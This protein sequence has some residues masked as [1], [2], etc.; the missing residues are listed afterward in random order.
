MRKKSWIGISLVLALLII[1]LLSLYIFKNKE[2]PIDNNGFVLVDDMTVEVYEDVLIS[3][4]IQSINGSII[5]D[6]KVK[7]DVLGK[8][9]IE[10]LYINDKGKKRKGIFDVEVVDTTGPI[11]LLN[12][13][14]TVTVGY[15]SNLV[16]IILS[17]DNYDSNPVRE[18]VGE[19]D[20]N[21]VGSYP[22]TYKVTDIN[23]NVTAKDFMLYVKEKSSNTSSNLTYTKFSDIVSLHK[24]GTT[25]VGIDISKWQGDIDFDALKSSGVEFVIIRIG[26]QLGFHESSL[27][28]PYFKKNIEEAT[29]VGIPIGIY[30]YSYATTSL[31]AKE[32]AF[33]VASQLNDY[34]I[35]LPVAFDWESWQYFNGLNMSIHDINDVASTFLYEIEKLGYDGILYGSKYYLNHIWETTEPVWLAHYTSKTDYENS[36]K[37]WQLCDNG[38]VDG[39]DGFVDINIMYE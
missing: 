1:I 19:Y 2:I 22:L 3:N 28:D 21:Q 11:I 9:T 32:Q 30:Y 34:S 18:I 31:E 38:K 14:Y 29:R 36:Y 33:W 8:Q 12:D 6:K 4:K 10:F 26:T 37:L 23:G 17:A 35:D 39:I 27:V 5:D 25:K 15:S 7:T 13:S 16:E 24:T 20:V